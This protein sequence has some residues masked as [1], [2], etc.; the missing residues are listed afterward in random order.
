MRLGS[1]SPPPT[2]ARPGEPGRSARGG[3]RTNAVADPADFL[4]SDIAAFGL[5]GSEFAR[6]ALGSSIR[7]TS[8]LEKPD[9]ADAEAGDAVERMLSRPVPAADDLALAVPLSAD[10][11]LPPPI[12]LANPVAGGRVA[13]KEFFA[14]GCGWD[15]GGDPATTRRFV[16]GSDPDGGNEGCSE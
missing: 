6:S 12:K 4:R 7:G 1:K 15:W 10:V 14:D 13:R 5:P 2:T 8:V 16:V 3:G 11:L 9:L